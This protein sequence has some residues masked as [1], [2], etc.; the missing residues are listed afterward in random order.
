MLDLAA[1]ESCFGGGRHGRAAGHGGAWDE[2]VRIG[3]NV[4]CQPARARG[5]RGGVVVAVGE[6]ATSLAPGDQVLLLPRPPLACSRAE[7]IAR[8]KRR[9]AAV[10]TARRGVTAAIASVMDGEAPREITVTP[11]PNE[12]PRSPTSTLVPMAQGFP[13][14]HRDDQEHRREAD[15]E[16]GPG[17]ER[18]PVRRHV[19]RSGA[20]VTSARVSSATMK[21]GSR[22]VRARPCGSQS[23][24][25]SHP[26]RG[27]PGA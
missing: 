12:E 20:G 2:I 25:S 11:A 3:W 9:P 21:R 22:P 19:R 17:E 24:A 1:P 6:G 18:E 27:D 5:R 7:A 26:S 14:G 23:C 15:C 13:C 8:W 10:N 4:G 16:C